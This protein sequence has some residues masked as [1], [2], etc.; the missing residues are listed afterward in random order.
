MLGNAFMGTFTWSIGPT[1]ARN[2]V[3]PDATFV[4]SLQGGPAPFDKPGVTVVDTAETTGSN[5]NCTNVPAVY[6]PPITGILTLLPP[7]DRIA[8][9]AVLGVPGDLE[10]GSFMNPASTITDSPRMTTV[11][12]VLD[13][14]NGVAPSGILR[15]LNPM[16]PPPQPPYGNRLY[17][18]DTS[19]QSL[20]V[21]NSYDFSLITTIPGVASPFGLGISPDL[22]Y[23]YVSNNLQG[24]IQRVNSNPASPQFH[25]VVNTIT[26]GN[27]PR[28]VSVHP[29]NEDVFVCNY[30]ENSVSIIRTNTQTER[31]RITT[32]LGPSDVFITRRMLCMGCTAEYMAFIPN[33]FSN[34][35][36]VYESNGGAVLE[37]NPQGRVIAT[38]TGF[39]GPARGTWNWVSVLTLGP[40][41]TNG[42]GCFVANTLG[43]SVDRIYLFSFT[44][45]PPPGFPGPPGTRNFVVDPVAS[46][47]S[48]PSD[49]S[50]DNMSG[51]YNVNVVGTPI[52]KRFADMGLGGGAASVLV[53][54]Y[55]AQGKCVAY[56]YNSPAF[57]A[58]VQVPGCDFL[59]AYYDQ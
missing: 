2:P 39:L 23:I 49:V 47:F 19:Q 33:V 44:L 12:G 16:L 5:L 18:T 38:Q 31:T 24:T 57:F 46:T 54:S 36:S 30:A 56:D 51:L 55:P 59:Q 10:V 11:P 3:P 8:N 53:V 9:T 4:G 42:P 41:G 34:S 22:Q 50:I 35:I 29:D 6:G 43:G 32:G 21:F 25:T 45:S 26:V 13:D 20:K 1:L 28:S 48:N 15:C 52:N 27:G 14:Q 17:V 40:S 37:N 58:E 7:T